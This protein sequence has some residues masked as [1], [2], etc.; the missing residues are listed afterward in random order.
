MIEWITKSDIIDRE[1][2][3]GHYPTYDCDHWHPG[4]GLID[5]YIKASS[6][7]TEMSFNEDTQTMT[8]EDID[9][10]ITYNVISSEVYKGKRLIGLGNSTGE[11]IYCSRVGHV[12][13]IVGVITDLQ[14]PYPR[15]GLHNGNGEST[16]LSISFTVRAT[17]DVFQYKDRTFWIGVYHNWS[18]DRDKFVIENLGKDHLDKLQYEGYCNN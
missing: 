16:L 9:Y 2:E 3:C 10:D 15:G 18:A 12:Y 17:D 8:E 7:G 4:D 1:K 6:S 14:K 11:Y 13:G 5:T